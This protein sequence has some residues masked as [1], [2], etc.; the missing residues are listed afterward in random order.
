MLHRRL[1]KEGPTVSSIGLGAMSFAG[2]YGEAQDS[3]SVATI[4]GRR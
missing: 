2:V 4:P 3:E 1:G